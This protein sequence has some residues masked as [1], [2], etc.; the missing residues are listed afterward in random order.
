MPSV[1]G[2]LCRPSLRLLAR[3]ALSGSVLEMNASEAPRVM[4][5][6]GATHRRE[7]G[8]A[9][10]PSSPLDVARLLG[11]AAVT[12]GERARTHPVVAEV[13]R[14]NIRGVVAARERG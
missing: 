4:R 9:A 3:S 12:V 11:T 1:A 10:A 2:S 14:D 13:A 5:L 6:K 7:D 8:A